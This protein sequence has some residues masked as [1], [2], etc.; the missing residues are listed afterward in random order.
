[1]SR[2]C[3]RF[4]SFRKSSR[5]NFGGNSIC[6]EAHTYNLEPAH[7]A[8]A[9]F[10]PN[11]RLFLWLHSTC[12]AWVQTKLGCSRSLLYRRDRVY[13]R[14]ATCHGS[15]RWILRLR[16]KGRHHKHPAVVSCESTALTASISLLGSYKF[17]P[18]TDD[19]CSGLFFVH[20]AR[21]N[22]PLARV[23]RVE[24]RR[25]NVGLPHKWGFAKLR[26]PAVLT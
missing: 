10:D 6:S 22:Q 18:G 9:I 20:T 23:V 15:T 3:L 4:L 1:M 12:V 11:Y 14:L 24:T 8:F 2:K 7:A 26:V 21:Y 13:K 19:F 16:P 5:G 25:D 17:S